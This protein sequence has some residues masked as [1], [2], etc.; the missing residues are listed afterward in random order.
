LAEADIERI[1][2]GPASRVLDVS[3]RQRFFLGATRRGC[4][5]R[6]RSCVHPS[7]DTPAARCEIDHVVPFDGSNTH[8]ANGEC[9]CRW[10]HARKHR[11]DARRQPP[12]PPPDDP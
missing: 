6:D 8:T 5:A 2:F 10:H 7:C 12:R 11:M 1:V 3:V 9:L 4:E